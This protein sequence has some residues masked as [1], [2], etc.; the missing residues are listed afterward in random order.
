[1]NCSMLCPGALIDSSS[2]RLLHQRLSRILDEPGKKQ[3]QQ[4]RF[5]P[6][7]PE[8]PPE[9]ACL[10]KSLIDLARSGKFVSLEKFAPST[11]AA[12]AASLSEDPLVPSMLMKFEADSGKWS[13]QAVA[14]EKEIRDFTAWEE[15]Y[16]LY[17]LAVSHDNPKVNAK[18]EAYRKALR[19]LSVEWHHLGWAPVYSY[20]KMMRR[21]F[22]LSAA[23][24]WA[25]FD[26]RIFANTVLKAQS[27][28]QAQQ[29]QRTSQPLTATG[30][31]SGSGA[32]GSKTTKKY[33]PC[34]LRNARG[35]CS[36]CGFRH[37]PV[38]L[39]C[40]KEGHW[41]SSCWAKQKQQQSRQQQPQQPFHFQPSGSNGSGSGSGEHQQQQ[42]HQPQQQ[43]P[44]SLP[45]GNFPLGPRKPKR[46]QQQSFGGGPPKNN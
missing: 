13:G 6:P 3:Q 43:R 15:A 4:Q 12:V 26:Q 8:E 40:K 2:A 16:E 45:S 18:L 14:K 36:G 38:C 29:Q 33:D 35:Q 28:A 22:P 34:C 25:V 20:D 31:G 30:S 1:M 24:K 37:D 42:Q 9:L 17:Q 23:E 46:Q 32:K 19:S 7:S 44:S 10:P 5:A 11:A 39:F 27:V 41:E 21:S